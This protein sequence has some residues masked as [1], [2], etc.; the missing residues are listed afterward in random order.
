MYLKDIS[1][2]EFVQC[3]ATK[4]ILP[5][6]KLSY[7]ERLIEFKLLP[8]MYWYDFQDI[9]FLLKCILHPPDNFNIFNYVSF[10]T[11]NTRSAGRGIEGSCVMFIR[12][13]PAQDTSISIVSFN[14]GTI[15]PFSIS[16]SHL[17]L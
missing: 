9:L 7:K 12:D 4:F 8:L 13:S 6:S 11:T 10:C 15:S 1:A 5:G 3:R 14:C 16:H 17:I 2:L